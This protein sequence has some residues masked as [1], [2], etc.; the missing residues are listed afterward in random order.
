MKIAQIRAIHKACHRRDL[1]AMTDY[2][3]KAGEYDAFRRGKYKTMRMYM[4]HVLGLECYH[5]K[6]YK[7]LSIARCRLEWQPDTNEWQIGG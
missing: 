5:G 3:K 4:R 6:I 2:L 1:E 7:S